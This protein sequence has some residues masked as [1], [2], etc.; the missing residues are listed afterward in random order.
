MT[1]RRFEQFPPNEP[2]VF[3]RFLE[4]FANRPGW[5]GIQEHLGNFVPHPDDTDDFDIRCDT[6]RGYITIEIQESQ[7][8]SA[9]G[10]LRL[11][12]VSSFR[13]QT[14]RTYS[15][16]DFERD[17]T[18]GRVRVEKW[19]KVVEP[20]ADFLVVEFRNGDTFWE[21]YD[22]AELHR[23][24][25]EFQEI[26]QFRTNHKMGESWGSAFL[27]VSEDDPVLQGAKPSTLEDVLTRAKDA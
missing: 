8:F 19:G 18:S 26:G 12:Y 5:E 9:W 13:P 22:L 21:I 2:A 24:L 25:P 6:P 4:N 27:A 3:R 15:L 20:K 23:L 17:V 11:D 16:L 7:D 10:D 1:G 14:Y